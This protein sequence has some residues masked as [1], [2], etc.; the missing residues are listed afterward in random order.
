MG[1]NYYWHEKPACEECGRPHE[2]IHIGKSSAG[3]CFSLHIHPREGIDSLGAW[4]DKWET[5]EIRDES[6]VL[7]KP[8]EMLDVITRRGI[9]DRAPSA[10]WYR[11]NH[12]EAGP[13]GLA[14]HRIDGVHC[15]SHGDG[16]WDHLLGD[17][18]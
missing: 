4:I 5:G 2:S 11:M 13:N 8:D 3:W 18:S 12:A 15:I 6:G 1:T 9:R 14:R 7:V 16:T 17:F 10:D